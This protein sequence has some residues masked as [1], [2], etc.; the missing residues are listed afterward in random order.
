MGTPMV[1]GQ[2][3]VV[4]RMRFDNESQ[5]ESVDCNEVQQENVTLR[6]QMQEQLK[7]IHQMKQCLTMMYAG[8]KVHHTESLFHAYRMQELI[9]DYTV[10]HGGSAE[11][12]EEQVRAF[13]AQ[14]DVEYLE[15]SDPSQSK[16][17]HHALRSHLGQILK[18]AQDDNLMFRQ[19]KAYYNQQLP[20]YG[21]IFNID[22]G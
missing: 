20:L 15:I 1:S 4:K 12:N 7:L 2:S 13:K 22:L 11:P 3:S 9:S 16:L 21:Q 8:K 6:I 5:E 17:L 10:T 19:Q 18:A 14:A